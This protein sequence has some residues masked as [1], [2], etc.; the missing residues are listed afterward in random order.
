MIEQ[1]IFLLFAGIV[2]GFGVLAVSLKNIFHAALC[3]AGAMFGVA[4]LFIFLGS[5]FIAVVQ[6]LIYLGAIGVLIIFA[7]M[8]SPPALLRSETKSAS[9]LFFCLS[10]SI[11]FFVVLTALFLKSNITQAGSDL[12]EIPISQLG[13]MLLTEFVFPF[14]VIALVLLLAIIG[15]V[16][17][18]WGGMEHE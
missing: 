18:A 1:L 7:I 14:E 3:F 8:I 6:I 4:G 11:S 2:L 12:G 13:E 10:V 16:M 15:A 17:H 5:E 9:K